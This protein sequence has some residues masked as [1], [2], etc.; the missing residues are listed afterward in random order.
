MRLALVADTFPP[1]RTS[2]A[3]QLLDLAKEIALR[4]HKLTVFIPIGSIHS[5][6]KV[7]EEH[8]FRVVYIRSPNFKNKSNLMRGLAELLLPACMYFSLLGTRELSIRWDGVIWYSPTIFLSPFV[9]LLKFKSKCHSYLILR[10]IFPDWLLDM[11]L[12]NKGAIYFF[13]KLAEKY[14]YS[15]ADTVGVQTNGNLSYFSKR[16]NCASAQRIEVLHNWLGSLGTSI[17]SIKLSNT[18]LK[19]RKIF[20]YTGNMGVAQGAGI[21]LE[22][23]KALIEKNDIGFLFVGRGTEVDKLKKIATDN[24][25]QNVLFFDEVPPQELESI[26]QQCIVG[27]LSLD[28]RHLSHNV[29]GKFLSYMRAGLPVLA[30][31]NAGND[32]INLINEKQVGKVTACRSLAQ[33]EQLAFELL[34]E[35]SF[36]QDELRFR[37]TLLAEEMFSPKI[38]ADQ[39]LQTFSN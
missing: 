39:I 22:L 6:Y 23:A 19:N 7:S 18:P 12:I 30:V 36:H 29:P 16:N 25:L 20:I 5:R 8:G 4:G 33:L 38:A 27:L 21:F 28:E 35:T 3:A 2:G 24:L 31:V 26:Y 37:C 14:Q 1:L 34:N 9:H 10:D 15:I 13:L 11:R 17:S 32:L